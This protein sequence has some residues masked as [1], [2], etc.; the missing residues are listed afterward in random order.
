M[1]LALRQCE[2]HLG[3]MTA[4]TVTWHSTVRTFWKGRG[5]EVPIH[6]LGGGAQE[7]G[8]LQGIVAIVVVC[9]VLEGQAALQV[10]L[11][12]VHLR[13]HIVTL[14][15]LLALVEPAQGGVGG[16]THRELDA[17]VVTPLRF[18]QL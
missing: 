16:A 4:L 8:G 11:E 17:G 1:M 13:A 9:G 15:D 2:C 12:D 7:V 18:V 5:Q 6:C 10:V 14:R 3:V